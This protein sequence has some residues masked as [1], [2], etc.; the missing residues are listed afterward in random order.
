MDTIRMHPE[1]GDQEVPSS[2][3]GPLRRAQRGLLQR[4]GRSIAD[5]RTP[6]V[7]AQRRGLAAV[8]EPAAA[9]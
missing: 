6:P 7:G 5:H 8:R 9:G 1:E 3:C 2:P 4:C